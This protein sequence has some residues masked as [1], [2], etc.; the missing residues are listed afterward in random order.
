MWQK[1]DDAITSDDNSRYEVINQGC[2]RS[3]LISDVTP[4]DIAM[5]TIKGL[6]GSFTVNLVIDGG[7]YDEIR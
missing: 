3:L 4:E 2:G 1:Y 5:Y 6:G 7:D